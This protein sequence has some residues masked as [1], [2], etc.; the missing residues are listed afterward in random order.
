MFSSF[1][2][3]LAMLLTLKEVSRLA[4]PSRI[5]NSHEKLSVC[6]GA[7]KGES[8]MPILSRAKRRAVS[9][10][11]PCLKASLLLLAFGNQE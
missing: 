11:S 9:S 3:A 2:L 7:W 5:S 4:A 6:G 8:C 1:A 10:R